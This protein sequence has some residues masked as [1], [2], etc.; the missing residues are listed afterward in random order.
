MPLVETVSGFVSGAIK[1]I[2]DK[3]IPD[4]KDRLEAELLITNQL[5]QINMGQLEINKE[6]AKSSSTFVAGWRPA[7]GWVCTLSF[8]YA[9]VGNDFLN[10]SMMVFT[11][12]TG[13]T[14]PAFPEPD[15]TVTGELLFAMLGLG[16]YRTY[17]K[18]KGITK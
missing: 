6:E 17:E 4:A 18:V 2:L 13:H 12:M 7:L 9:V 5:H 11:Q 10:W 16:G 15:T 14:V 1:P 3:F 8:A